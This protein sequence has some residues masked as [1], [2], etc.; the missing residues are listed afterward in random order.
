M[1]SIVQQSISTR[2][3]NSK[4]LYCSLSTK[5][6]ATNFISETYASS[7]ENSRECAVKIVIQACELGGRRVCGRASKRSQ[8]QKDKGRREREGGAST[9]E[10]KGTRKDLLKCSYLLVSSIEKKTY[11]PESTIPSSSA[12]SSI[13]LI[14][15][16]LAHITTTETRPHER[17]DCT[18]ARFCARYTYCLNWTTKPGQKKKCQTFVCRK[19]WVNAT[20]S[21][22]VYETSFILHASVSFVPLISRNIQRFQLLYF[23][24]V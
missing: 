10:V 18:N 21:C 14:V 13:S 1:V 7:E 17:I 6:A 11:S 22:G 12:A 2:R 19:L 24:S 4:I 15:V 5:Y 8:I 16:A 23:Q 3:N 9:K 20:N